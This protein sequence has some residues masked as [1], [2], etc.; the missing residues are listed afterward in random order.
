MLQFVE[1]QHQNKNGQPTAV[2][3]ISY[4]QPHFMK[5]VFN[6]RSHALWFNFF[7]TLTAKQYELA[8]VSYK[9][10]EFL[11]RA[12]LEGI[13]GDIKGKTD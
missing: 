8:A 5:H 13:K 4:Q 11:Y 6:C 7:I 3:I 9:T 12:G 1:T 2:Q 10:L